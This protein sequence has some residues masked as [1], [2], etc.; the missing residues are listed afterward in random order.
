[1]GL[2]LELCNDSILMVI[3]NLLGKALKVNE[4]YKTNVYC[5]VARILVKSDIYAS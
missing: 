3:T 4:F 2:P 1:M 5:Y